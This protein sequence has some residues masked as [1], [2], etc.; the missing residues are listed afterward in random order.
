[1]YLREDVAAR[2]AQ[3]L[4][5]CQSTRAGGTI[6]ITGFMQAGTGS[7]K[8]TLEAELRQVAERKHLPPVKAGAAGC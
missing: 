1:V 4:F 7:L 2:E 3:M 5:N 8:K 6:Y